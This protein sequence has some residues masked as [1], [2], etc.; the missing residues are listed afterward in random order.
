MWDACATGD[1]VAASVDGVDDVQPV[2]DV[3]DRRGVNPG[4]L[5]PI[6]LGVADLLDQLG[7]QRGGCC[8]GVQDESCGRRGRGSDDLGD[9]DER[10]SSSMTKEGRIS[11]S[12]LMPVNLTE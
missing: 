8:A 5:E 1:L 3:R 10:V 6:A 12:V 9:D 11:G 4:F 7:D 2:L